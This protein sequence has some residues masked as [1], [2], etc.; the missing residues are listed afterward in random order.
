MAMVTILVMTIL[1][2][3][4]YCGMLATESFE[5]MSDC[6]YFDLNWQALSLKLKKYCI[7]MIENM[8]QPIYYHGSGIVILDL[9]TFIQASVFLLVLK[10]IEPPTAN[11]WNVA[12]E[13]RIFLFVCAYSFTAI[14]VGFKVLFD[15]QDSHIGMNEKQRENVPLSLK[16]TRLS[17]FTVEQQG[18][19]SIAK[20]LHSI[21]LF[22]ALASFLN[23][24]HF[25]KL[26]KFPNVKYQITK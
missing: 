7:L 5:K 21:T 9:Y 17:Q 12:S 26:R 16:K 18:G 22:L 14:Q 25:N 13:N 19:R 4:C 8:Q 3:Y 10:A 24:S 23:C 11:L 15:V 1:F 20:M 2:G 6:I